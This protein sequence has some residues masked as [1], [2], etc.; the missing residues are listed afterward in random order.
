M[1]AE[2]EFRAAVRVHRALERALAGDFGA[3]AA[4]GDQ[5]VGGLPL[6]HPRDER[7]KGA[8]AAGGRLLGENLLRP[9]AAAVGAP[10]DQKAAEEIQKLLCFAVALLPAVAVCRCIVLLLLQLPSLSLCS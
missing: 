3:V 9:E 10:G 4:D 8:E 7:V 6:L 2:G 5:A 1:R